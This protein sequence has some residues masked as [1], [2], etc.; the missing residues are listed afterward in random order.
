MGGQGQI[1]RPGQ[2]TNIPSKHREMENRGST[3]RGLDMEL[4][5]PCF[6]FH[7]R[8]GGTAAGPKNYK[9]QINQGCPYIHLTVNGNPL[10][11]TCFTITC[12]ATEG[13]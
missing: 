6:F 9:E 3:S 7:I 4:R 12:A 13:E 10:W 2:H 11:A 8:T 1:Q 5:P